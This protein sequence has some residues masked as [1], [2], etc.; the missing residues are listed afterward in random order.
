VIIFFKEPEI[1]EEGFGRWYADYA[2]KATSRG[3]IYRHLP[4]VQAVI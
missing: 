2:S 1:K 3:G 4:K